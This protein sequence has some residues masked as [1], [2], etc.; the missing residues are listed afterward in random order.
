MT[1]ESPSI[2]CFVICFV[3]QKMTK[4]DIDPVLGLKKQLSEKEKALQEGKCVPLDHHPDALSFNQPSGHISAATY[5]PHQTV[6]GLVSPASHNITT[7]CQLPHLVDHTGRINSSHCDCLLAC[8]CCA[9]VLCVC[10][11]CACV[12]LPACMRA[13]MRALQM[14]AGCLCLINQYRSVLLFG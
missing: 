11:V 10:D 1:V 5:S 9:C 8:V 7:V 2:H 3:S 6:S 13:C 12:C 14:S 4:G